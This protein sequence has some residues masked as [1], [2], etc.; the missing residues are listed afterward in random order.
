V[1]SE[2]IFGNYVDRR[3]DSLTTRFGVLHHFSKNAQPLHTHLED[4]NCSICQNGG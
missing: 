2:R 4:G 1:N 3:G